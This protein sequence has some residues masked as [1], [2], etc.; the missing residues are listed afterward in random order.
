V[1]KSLDCFYNPVLKFMLPD[2]FKGEAFRLAAVA[3][4]ALWDINIYFTQRAA[5]PE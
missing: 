5:I 3:Y 1:I 2:A 4:E